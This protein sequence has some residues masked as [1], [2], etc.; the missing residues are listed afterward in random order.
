MTASDAQA[1]PT[2]ASP[3][4]DASPSALDRDLVAVWHLDETSGAIASDVFG[5]SAGSLTGGATWTAGKK[6]GALAFDGA[7]G[8]AMTIPNP[9]HIP[10]GAAFTVALWVRAN[11]AR[12]D[13]RLWAYGRLSYAKL[14]VRRPQL[15]VAGVYATSSR[16]IPVGEWH[17][18]VVTFDAG[19]VVWY[20]DGDPTVNTVDKFPDGG[21]TSVA[22]QQGDELRWGSTPDRGN[23]LDGALDE[24]KVWTRAL[25]AVEA[26]AVARE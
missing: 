18:L 24:V 6:N 16:S 11:E 10:L 5:K 8:T 20:V 21:V 14:N 9:V 7:D 3:P 2:D 1:A 17:H 13:Q 19:K 15:D 12:Y 26:A 23:V 25:S 4:V 22:S